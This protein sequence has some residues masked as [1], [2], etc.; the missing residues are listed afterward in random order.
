MSEAIMLTKQ[1]NNIL[2][3]NQPLNLPKLKDGE[4]RIRHKAIGIN[5]IDV[6][7]FVN[8]DTKNNLIPGFEASGIIEEIHKNVKN[9]KVGD[10]VAYALGPIGAY[11]TKRNIHA[12]HI[13]KLRNSISYEQAAAT[14]HK[15]MAAHYLLTKTFVVQSNTTLLIHAAA[16]GLGMFMTQIAKYCKAKV[17]GVVGSKDKVSNALSNG[18]DHVINSSEENFY[19]KVMSLTNNQGVDVVYDSVGKTTMEQSISCVNQL[20]LLVSVGNSSGIANNINFEAVR[21]N[22]IFITATNIFDYMSHNI[23]MKLTANIIFDL[24]EK[25]IIKD[26]I[27]QKYKLHEASLAIDNIANRKT[28]GSSVIIID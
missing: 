22:N 28:I 26:N 27:Y 8:S 11:C 6:E 7:Y 1:N 3:T 5:F 13:V 4:V 17:I 21:K 16:G 19:D 20:G 10:R 18:C 2:V 23:E 14:L 15:A 25:K 24:I 12:K 9:F